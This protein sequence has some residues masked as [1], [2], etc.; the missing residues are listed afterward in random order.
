MIPPLIA[1][2]MGCLVMLLEL[3]SH[4]MSGDEYHALADVES[5]FI[6]YMRDFKQN[7]S[8]KFQFWISYQFVGESLAG[9]RFLGAL[10]GTANLIFLCWWLL[11]KNCNRVVLTLLLLSLGFNTTTLGLSRWAMAPFGEYIFLSTVFI[12]LFLDETML[13]TNKTRKNLLALCCVLLPWLYLSTVIFITIALGVVFLV[14]LPYSNIKSIVRRQIAAWPLWIGVVSAI[15]ARLS[16]SAKN[17]TRARGHHATYED[18]L[19]ENAGAGL[20]DFFQQKST[21][22]HSTLFGTSFDTPVDN[23]GLDDVWLVSSGVMLLLGTAL[24]LVTAWRSRTIKSPIVLLVFYFWI[25][26]IGLFVLGVLGNFPYGKARYSM[27]LLAPGLI[28]AW[29]PVS[30]A[31]TFLLSRFEDRKL[32]QAM[33]ALLFSVVVIFWGQGRIAHLKELRSSERTEATSFRK[34]LQGIP[35]DA[36]LF[37]DIHWKY[38]KR[39]LS[40]SVRQVRRVRGPKSVEVLQTLCKQKIFKR[41]LIVGRRIDFSELKCSGWKIEHEAEYHSYQLQEIRRPE[42]IKNKRSER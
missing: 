4:D 19:G 12:L 38:P 10:A 2:L 28:I 5:G 40:P 36:V 35:A 37:A 24:T 8:I 18:W 17:W 34:A 41:I 23:Y 27:S 25:G 26:V 32:W 9:L 21:S 7:Y 33:A 11:G 39:L 3:G 31:M 22:L 30:E 20:L 15:G 29:Y 13:P 42:R 6:E 16:W 1:V 14:G